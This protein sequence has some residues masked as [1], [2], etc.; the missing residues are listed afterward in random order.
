MKHSHKGRIIN[1]PRRSPGMPKILKNMVFPRRMP[2]EIAAI[3][4]AI[5]TIHL[6]SSDSKI[7]SKRGL[8]FGS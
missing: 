4:T 8:L 2:A 5:G 7:P 6:G 1:K 3:K